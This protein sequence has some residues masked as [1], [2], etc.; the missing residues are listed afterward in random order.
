RSVGAGRRTRG[1]AVSAPRRSS[2]R[3]STRRPDNS[4]RALIVFGDLAHPARTESNQAVFYWFGV[5]PQTVSNWRKALGVGLTDPGDRR[6]A[7]PGGHAGEGGCQGRRPGPRGE[8]RG[9]KAG[10]SPTH[11]ARVGP[12]RDRVA[13]GVR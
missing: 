3:W 6:R 4:G 13:R 1:A 2:T 11:A 8:D 9:G 7:G 5:T 12:Q 10:K